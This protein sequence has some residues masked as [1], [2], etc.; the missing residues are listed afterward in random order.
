VRP[1]PFPDGY[2]IA[3]D[4]SPVAVAHNRAV[5][6][7]HA[8]KVRRWKAWKERRAARAGSAAMPPVVPFP[9]PPAA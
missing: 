3:L 2:H 9:T 6:A 1:N 8:E 5:L 4:P 7:E